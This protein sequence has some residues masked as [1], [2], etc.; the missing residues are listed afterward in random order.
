MKFTLSTKPLK[1]VIGLGIIKANISKYYYRSNVVQLTASRDTLKIN[2]EASGIKTKMVLRGSGDTDT[3]VSTIVECVKFKSL[4]DS[5]DADII[6]LEFIS[7]GIYVHAGHSSFSIPQLLDTD[8]VQLDEPD[9]EYT[10][11][12]TLTVNP[13]DWQFIHD[14]QMYAL[15][16][17]EDHPVYT[18]V[19]VSKD[20]DVLTGD[21][22]NSWFTYSKCGGFDTTCLLPASLINLLTSIPK[23]STI[24]KSGDSYILDIQTDSYS[25]VSEFLPKYESD[26][27]VGSYNSEIILSKL[28]HPESYITV[29]VTTIL[30]FINQANI[31]KS[32]DKDS[33]LEFI[34]GDETLLL[35]TSSGSYSMDVD[36][37]ESYEVNFKLELFKSVISNFD[38]D[39]INISPIWNGDSAVGCIF[40]TDRLTVMLAGQA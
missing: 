4:I 22:K 40:W 8:D 2:I 1:N 19:W 30:K 12:G 3:V 36:T 7:G 37:L 6:T 31:L 15:A 32:S 20:K 18:N 17:S 39:K 29:G 16:S 14:H 24:T 10:S 38:A 33:A 21:M 34:L 26:D 25:M 28:V 27:S 9:S 23:G 11:A 5:I 13:D 35:K